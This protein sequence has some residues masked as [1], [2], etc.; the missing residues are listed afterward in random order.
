MD[1]RND[2]RTISK[3]DKPVRYI[4]KTGMAMKEKRNEKTVLTLS[5]INGIR[6]EEDLIQ[7]RNENS[8]LESVWRIRQRKTDKI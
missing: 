1:F 7:I 8:Q 3:L 5:F 4:W 2:I 6:N